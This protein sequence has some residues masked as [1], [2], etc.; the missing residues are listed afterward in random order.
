MI[1]IDGSEKSGSGTILRLA[2]AMAAIKGQSL[3]ITNIRHKRPNPG[4]KHQHL[5]S[6]LTA[7]K[8]CNAE[9]RGASLGSSELWFTPKEIRGGTVEA[10]IE[11]AGSIPMLFL[12]TL[13]ICLFAHIPVHLHVARGGTDT[14]NAPTINY[15]RNILL[16][17]LAKMG[18]EAEITVQKYGYYPKGVGEATL[19]V[20]PTPCLMPLTLET[21]G[22]LNAVGGVSVCTFLADRQ[23][24]QRQ[25][26]A[27]QGLLSQN[28]YQTD[29]QVVNDQSNPIQKGSSI[30][31]WAKTSTSV[32]VG[33]DS[34]GELQKTAEEVGRE[35]AQR[36]ITELAVQPTVD[37]FLADMLIPYMALSE[38]RSVFLT[39]GITEHIESNIWL[40]EKILNTKFTL[41]K[42]DC[43]YRI[44]KIS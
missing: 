11:T 20:K 2:V 35:A 25:A 36:L 14:R 12:S 15:L 21:F 44:E 24:A 29:I 16:P 41:T 33:A 37:E 40:M 5:E 18:I 22:N 42:L 19:R 13:P 31:L 10:V 30:T 4:L 1:D 8:L 34:L 27:A 3:H 23:V 32:I 26:R 43:L 6:V 28:G 7:A 39:R 38:G 9:V 17:V